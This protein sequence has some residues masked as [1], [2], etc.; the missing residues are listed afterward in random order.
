MSIIPR[1][2]LS[3]ALML[4]VAASPA[5]ADL[6]VDDAWNTWRAQVGALGLSLTADE[7][8][9]GDALQIGPVTLSAEFPM[10]AGSVAISFDGPR[11]APLG[12]GTVRMTMP[13][14]SRMSLDGEITGEGSLSLV[15]AVTM[16]DVDTIMSGTPD[17][18]VSTGTVEMADLQLVSL[19]VDGEALE[20]V[21]GSLTVRGQRYQTLTT[22]G[23][24]IG[25]EA[26]MAY[27]GYDMAYEVDF[28]HGEAGAAAGAGIRASG[29]AR[30]MKV[31]QSMRLPAGG[32]D[33][34]ALHT[35]L[36]EGLTVSARARAGEYGTTQE[37]LS[38]GRMLSRQE[39]RAA[40]YDVTMTLDTSGV[41]W[42]G[43]A[44]AFTGEMEV[45][46][47]LAPISVAGTSALGRVRMPLLANEA[48]QDA[49]LRMAFEGL[50]L[51]D[52]IWALADPAGQLPRD[53]MALNMDLSGQVRLTGDL[54]DFETLQ[55]MPDASG[56]VVPVSA[57]LKTLLLSAV[58]AELTGEGF[59]EF[60]ETDTDTFPGMPRPEGAVDLR[61]TGGNALLDR[62]VAMGMIPEDQA[63]SARMMMGLFAVPGEG[64]DTLTSKIEINGE[65]HVLANGQRLK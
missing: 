6:T 47:M 23:E 3:A 8:R 63:M 50:T 38:D 12:D 64:E 65:G 49:S 22:I 56:L 1:F 43:S 21:S 61:L 16:P 25:I 46:E 48:A 11:F 27:D 35:H 28:G 24:M 51:N 34:M 57:G 45:A 13:E 44:G 42:G 52:E 5:L 60:D 15:L 62:L 53:P 2:S 29:F 41:V 17:R 58:G 30:D 14:Q 59:F 20:N 37:V 7:S 32:L 18:V 39:N 26:D 40:E 9:D 55:A 4:S 54:L 31:S 19:T 10:G 33:L 36:R